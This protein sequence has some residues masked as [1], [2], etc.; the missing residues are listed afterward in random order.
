MVTSVDNS[1]LSSPKNGVR[2]II[3]RAKATGQSKLAPNAAFAGQKVLNEG[4]RGRVAALANRQAQLL[5]HSEAILLQN[6]AVPS[7]NKSPA[8]QKTTGSR[9]IDHSVANTAQ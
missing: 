5:Q 4:R 7:G 2:P 9:N 1:K 8:T 3:G 6:D